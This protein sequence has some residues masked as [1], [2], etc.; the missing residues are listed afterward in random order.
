MAIAFLVIMPTSTESALRRGRQHRISR[1]ERQLNNANVKGKFR[2]QQ[3][4]IMPELARFAGSSSAAVDPKADSTDAP[5]AD[6]DMVM[7]EDDFT[8]TRLKSGQWAMGRTT[9]EVIDNALAFASKG[10][11]AAATTKPVSVKYGGKVEF[12][13]KYDSK[14][15][16]EN[17][18]VVLAY[19][20]DGSSFKD[21]VTY[22]GANFDNLFKDKFAKVSILI[23][24]DHEPNAMTRHTTF[25]WYQTSGKVGSSL[26]ET[27]ELLTTETDGSGFN[28]F[29]AH[30]RVLAINVPKEKIIFEDDFTSAESKGSR[31]WK[32]QG[33]TVRGP[34]KYT[35]EKDGPLAFSGSGMAQTSFRTRM[36]FGQG[37]E[38]KATIDK[39]D[40]CSSHWIALS[41]SKQF[42]WSWGNSD[43]VI[44]FAWNCDQKYIYGAEGKTVDTKCGTIGR[45]NLDIIIEEGQV[46]FKDGV[47]D[48]L[49][50]TT[51][52]FP[53]KKDRYYVYIGADQ[54]SFGKKSE[55]FDVKV[56]ELNEPKHTKTLVQ[57]SLKTASPEAFVYPRAFSNSSTDFSY[58]FDT[59]GLFFTGV[60]K[61]KIPM[62]TQK[63]F[64][65]GL[66]IKTAISKEDSCDDHFIVVSPS[67]KYEWSWEDREDAL[68]FVWN[69]GDKFAYSPK[70][71]DKAPC[72]G[73]G[74]YN[75]EIE[76]SGGVA[77]FKDSRCRTLSVKSPFEE[78][79]PLYVYVG[80]DQDKP[81]AKAYYLS[82]TDTALECKSWRQT[83]SCDPEG[84]RE[85]ASDKNC[86]AIVSKASSGYCEC[87]GGVK[88]KK[89]A[90]GHEE[91]TCADVCKAK[92]APVEKGFSVSV[93][94]APEKPP[95]NVLVLDSFNFHDQINSAMWNMDGVT[96]STDKKC[97]AKEGSSL[98][99]FNGGPRILT[100]HKLNVADGVKIEFNI[101]YGSA[102]TPDC[103]G[104]STSTAVELQ[105]SLDGKTFK[106]LVVYPASLYASKFSEFAPMTVFVDFTHHPEALS[107]ATSFR[108]IEP[109][110]NRAY[111][112][113]W[114][115][116]H[117]KISVQ[118]KVPEPILAPGVLVQEAFEVPEYGLNPWFWDMLSTTARANAMCG[119][120]S[121]AQALIFSEKDEERK[122][123][124]KEFDLSE[125]AS[126]VFNMV[127]GCGGTS[128]GLDKVEVQFS[129]DGGR[130]FTTMKTFE[131]KESAS[132]W[133]AESRERIE[134]TA[135]APFAKAMNKHTTLRFIQ[136]VG[137]G[138]WAI[139]DLEILVGPARIGLEDMLLKKDN[140]NWCYQPARAIA[141]YAYGY[142]N[143][144]GI[145]KD[146]FRDNGIKF[147]GNSLGKGSVRSHVSFR[148]DVTITAGIAGNGECTNHFIV[149]SAKRYFTWNW[150]NEPDSIKFVWNCDRKL[151]IGP[152]ETVAKACPQR[153]TNSMTITH[154]S[155]G[156][157][158]TFADGGC[159]R[160]ASLESLGSRDFYVYIGS[161]HGSSGEPELKK[162]DPPDA[163]GASGATGSAVFLEE[164]GDGM[165]LELAELEAVLAAPTA[166][167]GATLS[168][169][170]DDYDEEDDSADVP[171]ATEEEFSTFKYVRVAGRGSVVHKHDLADKCPVTIDCK[172]SSWSEFSKCSKECERGKKTRTRLALLN[173]RN[174][175]SACP[176]MSESE[177]CNPFPCDC[178]V[179]E[180]SEWATCTAPCS[181][182]NTSRTRKVTRIKRAH[183]KECPALVEDKFCNEE[184]CA[185]VG[186]PGLGVTKKFLRDTKME[187][188]TGRDETNWCYQPP[189]DLLPYKY[190]YDAAA[191]GV[192]FSGRSEGQT[193][194]RSR[195]SFQPQMGM[196]IQALIPKT[197]GCSN[198]FIMLSSDDYAR[199]NWKS[200][201]D[202]IKFAYK[203]SKKT[204]IVGDGISDV[205]CK[206]Q[207]TFKAKVQFKEGK[208]V[209]KDNGCE[210]I[211]VPWTPQEGKSYYLYIGADP[212]KSK[213][214]EAA[215]SV[216]AA[217]AEAEKS[218]MQYKECEREAKET[219]DDPEDCK[220]FLF[221]AASELDSEPD[222][223]PHKG[224]GASGGTGAT[225]SG[226]GL[227]FGPDLIIKD[228]TGATGA[229]EDDDEESAS[230]ASGGEDKEMEKEL[231][232]ED[233]EEDM[234]EKLTGILTI[235]SMGRKAFSEGEFKANLGTK[236]KV[237]PSKITV[238]AVKGEGSPFTVEFSLDLGSGPAASKASIFIKDELKRLAAESIKS[239][240]GE[241]IMEKKAKLPPGSVAAYAAATG[242][243]GPEG[244]KAASGEPLTAEE[245]AK[246]ATGAPSSG[247]KRTEEKTPEDFDVKGKFEVTGYTKEQFDAAAQAKLRS[248]VSSLVEMDVTKVSINAVS[249]KSAIS[250]KLSVRYLVKCTSS[251]ESG[252]V[253]AALE[254][255]EEEGDTVLSTMKENGLDKLTAAAAKP[256]TTSSTV[257]F[258]EMVSYAYA[259]A[260]GA[261]SAS[262]TADEGKAMGASGTASKE[263]SMADAV[264][265]VEE[266]EDEKPEGP[267]KEAATFVSTIT[268]VRVSGPGSIA[269]FTR[270]VL[271][272]CPE[273]VDCVVGEWGEWGNCTK[274]CDGGNHTRTRAVLRAADNGGKE[275]PALSEMGA[276]NARTCDCTVS[277]WGGWGTCD[278]P[279][280]GGLQERERHVLLQPLADGIACP[281]LKSKRGCN[282]QSCAALG[283]PEL[284]NTNNTLPTMVK[285][286]SSTEFNK[287]DD[288]NWCY[289]EPNTIAPYMYSVGGGAVTFSGNPSGKGTMR[290]RTELGAPLRVDTVLSRKEECANHFVVFSTERYYTWNWEP[291]PGAIKFAWDCNKKVIIGPQGSSEIGCPLH[292]KPHTV[293]TFVYQN[294]VA[295]FKDSH[296]ADVEL[297]TDS[298]KDQPFFLYIG[299]APQEDQ[300]AAS[301]SFQAVIASGP[302]S[303]EFVGN[304]TDKPC[305]GLSD[306]EV[307]PWG[308]WSACDAPCETGHKFR[309]RTVIK[310]AEFGGESCP[311]LKENTTCNT[312]PCGKDCI[313]SPWEPWEICD[314]PCGGGLQLRH[315]KVF[316][317]A[318]KGYGGGKACPVLNESRVCN[319]IQCGRDCT[320]TEFG[321]W[322]ECSVNCGGG[323]SSRYRTVVSPAV[324]GHRPGKECPE[325]KE[326][327][328][329]NAQQCP[330]LEGPEPVIPQDAIEDIDCGQ[331]TEKPEYGY[332][333]SLRLCLR[334][335]ANGPIPEWQGQAPVSLNAQ[336]YYQYKINCSSWQWGQCYGEPCSTYKDCK[337]C[338][339]DTFCGWCSGTQSCSEGE[340][341]GSTGQYCPRGWIFSPLGRGVGMRQRDDTMMTGLQI[342]KQ[343][344]HLSDFCEANEQQTRDLIQSKINENERR[345]E[346]LRLLR[347]TCHPCFKGTWPNCD[348]GGNTGA[349][350]PDLNVELVLHNKDESAK[351]YETDLKEKQRIQEEADKKAQ[352]EALK[353]EEEQTKA[354]EAAQRERRK[355][356]AE[357]QEEKAAAAAAKKAEEAQKKGDEQA[358]K[359]A[360]AQEVALQKQEEA[361]KVKEAEEEK[362]AK[363]EKQ[364]AA[365]EQ[366]KAEAAADAEAARRA[367]KE[368][369]EKRRAEEL[370]KATL[371]EAQKSGDEEAAKKAEAD[372]R[373]AKRAAEEAAK[374]AEAK[375]KSEEEARKAA[376]TG[377]TGATGPPALTH[378]DLIKELDARLGK[379]LKE[380]VQRNEEHLKRLIARQPMATGPAEE[381]VEIEEPEPVDEEEFPD[382]QTDFSKLPKKDA[383]KRME[384]E[385]EKHNKHIVEKA[386]A[387]AAKMEE[388]AA[389]KQ[390]EVEKQEAETQKKKDQAA[391]MKQ[392]LVEAEAVATDTEQQV[393]NDEAEKN[394][395]KMQDVQME[396]T[397]EQ[398]NA[399]DGEDALS[400]AKSDLARENQA[401]TA[402]QGSKKEAMV[403]LD[404]ASTPLEKKLAEGHI[405]L[406]ERMEKA[407]E[408]TKAQLT[409][410]VKT[411][412]S[413][414]QDKLSQ[415]NN[416][417]EESHKQ[418]KAVR[419]KAKKADDQAVSK[420]QELE[421]QMSKLDPA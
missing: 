79:L 90:C 225:G 326:D 175:G 135:D 35:Y 236:I 177:V 43:N 121:G 268:G 151:V 174:G 311:A 329:C 209:F 60:A 219:G 367:E 253:K 284:K 162:E 314:K 388:K 369:A 405:A 398:S 350:K 232:A 137:K 98:R 24:D 280:G 83:G 22:S 51:G 196:T 384:K 316:K 105:Y 146:S 345:L 116:D 342:K 140:N 41:T 244:A 226:G 101:K 372:A 199:F 21:I 191:P 78:D 32:R 416:K 171:E 167:T 86:D 55:F 189:A 385:L 1:A 292:I 208:V 93:A 420:V 61:G 202:S 115:I 341:G 15:R 178:E 84:K 85:P 52:K 222:P 229:E 319:E 272:K 72:T 249:S 353:A 273:K 220:K 282:K 157:G 75:I 4:A 287:K 29:L 262:G 165:D 321:N 127:A 117:V 124:T 5:A 194:M 100:T 129:T 66:S 277:G 295:K 30:V 334:G 257:S 261:S 389:A 114:A 256:A 414:L 300:E 212:Q 297:A 65:G 42:K 263:S 132:E 358:E 383:L 337:S 40:K 391:E 397:N 81:G 147:T 169:D 186:L 134:V 31:K 125:G 259:Y 150:E 401:L 96:G 245:A 170:G 393:A 50:L 296:C 47:C 260:T 120:K 58:G 241:S 390:A 73:N 392:K 330:G 308:N 305:P 48:D 104:T 149:L 94:D 279:C 204:V 344:D 339:S 69:C 185:D 111:D 400:N 215:E 131:L 270:G 159:E 413:A 142:A 348:C 278:K 184:S 45:Y 374:A 200:D 211:E 107:E 252:R 10:D 54:D 187:T 34:Y 139:D 102:T 71:S 415:A 77:L 205:A 355:E 309:S 99:F 141:P 76:I 289:Q 408:S 89:V 361:E 412:E 97:G 56:L 155:V 230:G 379:N 113:V 419:A 362:K 172:V 57:D 333:P 313:V 197:Q 312:A 163:S 128:V 235:K 275:C 276:C 307:S 203:C 370:A 7:M 336:K 95:K 320:V 126:I 240:L 264:L 302:G 395:K 198:Q 248:A 242:A 360:R 154:G 213:E 243:S 39:T 373:D 62:R 271:P 238:V 23:D 269:N 377:S 396:R 421:V 246:A 180:W 299:A 92:T 25:R 352:A 166:S 156:S 130:K 227:E 12:E 148:G 214:S 27:G 158:S 328:V 404:T 347:E 267:D 258:I 255:L 144:V 323:V 317:P 290:S 274:P 108:W 407:A 356:E 143:E 206:T 368:R 324:H 103:L 223:M 371:E 53:S 123:T 335:T 59:K 91:F 106:P 160:L 68:K 179:G 210:D 281:A 221:A 9:G 359:E 288:T 20:T 8:G 136:V 17:D 6:E 18:A 239:S 354:V 399:K 409:E 164:S 119:A 375:E 19:S 36:T 306:C 28:W 283:V 382:D 46:V 183:G 363:E 338:M 13:L 192:W 67:A 231:E 233:A 218:V 380:D 63:T 16:G 294:G 251:S 418:A 417:A 3:S 11:T 161:A 216:K 304:K 176:A 234:P 217:D 74:E 315:R 193:T 322:S 378:D 331:C 327:R 318:V 112:N 152:T 293:A 298:L 181:R 357:K 343:G 387:K 291:E 26:L 366:E 37:T 332:C 303:L 70:E 340:V 82:T 138:Q 145:S 133:G 254:E 207:Q 224:T 201:P 33:A 80:A 410:K 381:P 402:A 325:L 2:S 247:I 190:G 265:D 195:Q 403:E 182:G 266:D 376:H 87:E 349:A 228:A 118:P 285:L 49:L 188:F 109:S 351:A 364:R 88:A 406:A 153:K 250:L 394:V 365:E 173:P 301:A 286:L 168:G 386:K 110:D 14:S 237:K 44:K 346:R 122:A 310:E 411:T 64:T 38:I